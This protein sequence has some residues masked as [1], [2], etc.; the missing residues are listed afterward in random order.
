LPPDAGVLAV[1]AIVVLAPSGTLP[2]VQLTTSPLI[3]QVPRVVVADAELM[4]LGSVTLAV[5][6]EA[7]LGPLF[8]MVYVYVTVLFVVAAR[9]PV[10]VAAMS[11]ICCTSTA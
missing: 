10:T 2:N 7:S 9:G 5:T 3:A 4:P 6:A 8:V 1:T 11:A